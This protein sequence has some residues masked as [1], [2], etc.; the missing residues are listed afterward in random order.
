MSSRL[1]QIKSHL[2]SRLSRS[3]LTLPTIFPVPLRDQDENQQCCINISSIISHFTN[4]RR[5]GTRTWKR[6]ERDSRYWKRV[7]DYPYLNDEERLLAHLKGIDELPWKEIVVKFNDKMGLEMRQ[8]A[9]QMRLTRLAFRMDVSLHS[10]L[11]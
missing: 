1:R 11:Q 4:G 7:Y 5:N 2:P 10:P 9:L 3:C 8:P 6:K